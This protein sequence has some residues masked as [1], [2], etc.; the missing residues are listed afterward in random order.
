MTHFCLAMSLSFILVSGLAYLTPQDLATADGSARVQLRKGLIYGT[1][2]STPCSIQ[3]V[4]DVWSGDEESTNWTKWLVDFDG[5]VFD[6]W[7]VSDPGVG[8]ETVQIHIANGRVTQDRNQF[9]SPDPKPD[10]AKFEAAMQ[11]ALD[12]ALKTAPPIPITKNPLKEVRY[13]ITFMSDP[14]RVPRFGK[15]SFGL[16]AVPNE[17]ADNVIVYGR[18]KEGR[19]PGIQII[20]EGPD[21]GGKIEVTEQES[22]LRRCRQIGD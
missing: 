2:T 13:S 22:F 8:Q 9:M 1:L 20:N 12:D 18:M 19:A 14:Q 10:R 11:K 15:E 5:R 7:V 21:D 3:L 17:K 16:V 4:P 6:K